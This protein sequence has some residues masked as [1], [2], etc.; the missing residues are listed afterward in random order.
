MQNTRFGL[1]FTKTLT[2]A[3]F[4]FAFLF[5]SC[6]E[7]ESLSLATVGSTIVSSIMES[8][9]ECV[10]DVVSEGSSPVV[11]RGFCWSSVHEPTVSDAVL[12]DSSGSGSFQGTISGLQPGTTYQI[13]AYAVS[14]VGTAYGASTSFTTKVFSVTTTTPYFVL[15]TSAIT[16]GY[17]QTD[18][19]S[20]QILA[21][22][23][24]WNT[25]PNP[26]V[27]DSVTVEGGWI[28]GFSSTMKHL[29]PLTTYYVRAY[30]TTP[31]RTM[32][33]SEFNF[34]TQSGIIGV[35]TESVLNVMPNTATFSGAVSGDG[36][37]PTTETG[38]V[39][40]LTSLPTLSDFRKK[41]NV[42]SGH[43][44]CSVTGLTSNVT[45][46]LRAYAINEAG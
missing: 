25:F 39:W 1:R 30:V 31:S 34:T 24:C 29:K 27:Q 46:H 28:G 37:A 35:T 12:M 33:G 19:D 5:T 23:V 21:R 3:L 20:T 36:G 38:F 7:P 40:G 14:D 8:S 43:F 11:T 22:G 15:A 42:T 45:Y 17:L 4:L 10:G 9:V 13:R 32:Y 16:G 2:L 18:F 44:T 6:E 41:S 26:T